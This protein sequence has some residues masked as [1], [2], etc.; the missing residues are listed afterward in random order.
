MQ[1]SEYLTC[2]FT[3]MTHTI[4][5]NTCLISEVRAGYAAVHFDITEHTQVL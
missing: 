2:N 3:M 5:K 4:H 1:E